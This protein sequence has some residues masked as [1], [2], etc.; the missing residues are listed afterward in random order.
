M[1]TETSPSLEALEAA[2]EIYKAVAAKTESE[3]TVVKF[4]RIIDRYLPAPTGSHAPAVA[5]N[6]VGAASVSINPSEQGALPREFATLECDG[7]KWRIAAPA[8]PAVASSAPS[9]MDAF[10]LAQLRHLYSQMVAGVVEDQKLA[11]DGLLSPAISH[12]ER[13]VSAPAVA[14]PATEEAAVAWYHD[15]HGTIELSRVQRVGWKPLFSDEHVRERLKEAE[16]KLADEEG[17]N[18]TLAALL[19]KYSERNTSLSKELEQAVARERESQAKLDSVAKLGVLYAETAKDNRRVL[20]NRDAMRKAGLDNEQKLIAD[21]RWMEAFA[22]EI[23]Q[24]LTQ[25][26]NR[27]DLPQANPGAEETKS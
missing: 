13:R 10:Q 11:A 22:K 15:D 14:E 21:T 7:D 6:G 27:S 23:K 18:K 16:A 9:G 19:N 8:S 25:P 24:R 1:K 4:A 17:H 3:I 20:S 26:A 2:F 12:F 5:E